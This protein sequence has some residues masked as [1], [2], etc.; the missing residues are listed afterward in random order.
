MNRRDLLTSMVSVPAIASITHA[1]AQGVEHDS[2]ADHSRSPTVALVA[3]GNTAAIG[4]KGIADLP[5]FV[6]R[7]PPD[8]LCGFGYCSRFVMPKSQNVT[9]WAGLLIQSQWDEGNLAKIREDL[10][11]TDLMVLVVGV[12][13]GFSPALSIQTLIDVAT[14]LGKRVEITTILETADAT[15]SQDIGYTA[16]ANVELQSNVLLTEQHDCSVESMRVLC[17]QMQS[18]EL[19][20]SDF[21]HQYEQAWLARNF[22]LATIANDALRRGFKS[23]CLRA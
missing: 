8:S 1:T 13:D 7:N 22:R 6:F 20:E 3:W 5:D 14:Q 10:D 18:S 9:D 17:L 16:F 21:L 11:G 19:T 23:L 12:R 4:I 2:S 15:S